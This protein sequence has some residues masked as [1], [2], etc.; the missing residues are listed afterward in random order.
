[1]GIVYRAYDPA[2]DRDVAVKIMSSDVASDPKYAERLL[3][4]AR[5]MAKVRHPNILG[6]YSAGWEENT[7]YVAMELVNGKSLAQ[8]LKERGALPVPEALRIAK[9]AASALEAAQEAGVIHRDVKPDNI[10]VD[11]KG[12][13][14]VMDF[15][16]SRD[17]SSNIS[18]TKS[19]DYVGTPMYSSPEQWM[20][21]ELDIR[22]DIYSLG[23]V[24]YEMIVGKPP[25]NSSNPLALMKMV[26]EEGPVP[27]EK[28]A[29]TL[30]A[31]VVAL[32][33][34]MIAKDPKN[35]FAS[36]TQLVRE[37]EDIL[38]KQDDKNVT[39]HTNSKPLRLPPLALRLA[40]AFLVIIAA[41][42]IFA[43][44]RWQA[45]RKS[46]AP[47]TLPSISETG[48]LSPANPSSGG[49]TPASQLPEEMTIYVQEFK[50]IVQD[51]DFGWLANGAPD[52]LVTSLVQQE[53][54][55]VLS[56]DNV[57]MKME[58]MKTSNI[59]EV[60][61]ALGGEILIEG[62]YI[63]HNKGIQFFVKVN[64]VLYSFPAK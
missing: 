44:S 15:G 21:G 35:R 16:L 17:L 4:E 62:E 39:A 41:V 8:I 29:P 48:K 32:V 40:A 57:K 36:A 1:M 13:A 28:I 10:L 2:L 53:W 3:R 33:K 19:C 42:S 51:S 55:S 26:L 18:I 24:L 23:I 12:R 63:K 34:R 30:P 54:L 60:V 7:L 14:K 37:L 49:I 25:F 6:V 31:S 56:S 47:E 50:P 9:D 59:S 27:I 45:A 22:S 38:R 11:A 46:I 43:A 64:D 52:L 61:R 20:C 5:I 58:E